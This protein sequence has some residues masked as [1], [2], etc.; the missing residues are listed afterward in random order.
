MNSSKVRAVVSSVLAVAALSACGQASG[1]MDGAAPQDAAIA[2]D[3]LGADGGAFAPARLDKLD[4]LVLVDNSGSMADKQANLMA[5]LGGLLSKLTA[6][7][8]RSQRDPAAPL[9]ACEAGNADLVPAFNAVTSLN[10][11]VITP[12]LGTPGSTVIGCDAAERGDHGLLKRA[13]HGVSCE[14]HRRTRAA[15]R[16]G[17]DLRRPVVPQWNGVFDLRE[18]LRPGDRRARGSRSRAD[19]LAVSALSDTGLARAA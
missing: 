4:L 10:V 9:R 2:V 3:G 17:R 14:A 5:Q 12:D 7:L 8:C 19:A 15:L 13:V 6:P 18:R 16:P 1:P 11:G